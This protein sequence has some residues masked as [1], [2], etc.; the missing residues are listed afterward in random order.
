MWSDRVMTLAR[1]TAVPLPLA[2]VEKLLQNVVD[3]FK[4]IPGLCSI[5]V[6]GSAARGTM[7][8]AS[9]LDILLVFH[10]KEDSH[11]AHRSVSRYRKKAVWPMDFLCVDQ[12]TFHDKSQ[13]GGV[14]FVI[15]EEGKMIYGD[16][17]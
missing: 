2:D 15:R 8:D 6:F 5:F 1:F 9:D 13:I 17:I 3:D 14:Y 4:E 12:K 11:S 16:K 7:T 10:S